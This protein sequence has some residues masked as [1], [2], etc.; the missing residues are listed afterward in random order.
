VKLS[1]ALKVQRGETPAQARAAS[2]R[3]ALPSAPEIA[4]RSR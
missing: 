3:S 4:R 1:S 2:A